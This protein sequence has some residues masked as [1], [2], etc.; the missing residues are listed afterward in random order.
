MERRHEEDLERPK[1]SLLSGSVSI[2][3]PSIQAYQLNLKQK[4]GLWAKAS[5]VI[6]G[7]V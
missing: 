5:R 3:E 7:K 4:R 1:I 2:T 6:R